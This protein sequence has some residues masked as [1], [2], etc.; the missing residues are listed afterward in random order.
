[1]ASLLAGCPETPKPVAQPSGGASAA[2]PSPRSGGNDVHDVQYVPQNPSSVEHFD[3]LGCKLTRDEN[4]NVTKLDV[5]AAD[6]KDTDLDY[7]K[8]LPALVDLDLAKSSITDNG[9]GILASLP[10]LKSLGLQRCNLI[11]DA[12]LQH[13]DHVPNL[14]RLYVLYTLI[15]DDGMEHVAKLKQLRVL[16]LRGTKVGDA[17][18]EKLRDHPALVDLKL[19]AASITDEG[20][21]HIATLKQ[22]RSLEAEDTYVTDDGLPHLAA[23]TELQ[24][25]N[26]WRSFVSEVGFEKLTGLTKLRDLRLRGT[27][28]RAKV[29]GSLT[30]AKDTLVYL[31]LIECPIDDAELA[32]IEPF[33]KLETLEIWQTGLGD[34]GLAHIGKLASLKSLD[35]SKCL[36]VTSAGVANLVKLSKL[37]ALNLSETGINDEALEIL[38]QLHGLK[39]L[40]VRLTSVTDEGVAKFKAAVPGCKVTRL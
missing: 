20:M 24:K 34:A 39:S 27:A 23:L 31:D 25:L 19:R 12:G 17:G 10:Q 40:D 18:L 26:L 6:L 21:P 9:L 38:A 28:T 8:D 32:A 1:M 4:G 30:G 22:L 11:T 7:L 37:D 33:Q 3:K 15:G 35:V 14:E 5:V 2:S 16:D 29:L 13:L 36:K